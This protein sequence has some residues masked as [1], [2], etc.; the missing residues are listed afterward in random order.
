MVGGL[1]RLVHC[2][3]LPQSVNAL[4]HTPA[5]V[6]GINGLE[7][8]QSF[9]IGCAVLLHNAIELTGDFH[10]PHYFSLLLTMPF[11]A[12]TLALLA[13]NW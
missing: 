1:N 4:C 8:G 10:E 7:A 5:I 11:I 13:Y 12:V 6:A 3:T 2:I 9:I